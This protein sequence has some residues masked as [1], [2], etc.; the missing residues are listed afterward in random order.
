[1]TAYISP[2]LEPLDIELVRPYAV[3]GDV[4]TIHCKETASWF[5]QEVGDA[6]PEFG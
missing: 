5:I 1:M 2:T 4:M 6:H 3:R